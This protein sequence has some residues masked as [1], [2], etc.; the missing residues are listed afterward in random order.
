MFKMKKIRYATLGLLGLAACHSLAQNSLAPV[1]VTSGTG[2]HP[3]TAATTAD[4]PE[5]TIFMPANPVNEKLPIVLWGN[6]GCMENALAYGIFLR[7]IASH[8]Y[9]VIAAGKPLN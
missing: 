9:L 6:G 3:A 7:E 4:M 1:S 2:A 8:G 5:N